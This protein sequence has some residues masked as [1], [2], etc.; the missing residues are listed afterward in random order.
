MPTDPAADCVT[1][2][3]M[4]LLRSTQD[5]KNMIVVAPSEVVCMF[6]P[7][8]VIGTCV[9]FVSHELSNFLL[10]FEFL[11]L[12]QIHLQNQKGM[13]LLSLI[14]PWKPWVHSLL[15]SGSDRGG[16]ECSCKAGGGEKRICQI[17]A[18]VEWLFGAGDSRFL[19]GHWVLLQPLY[20]AVLCARIWREGQKNP[21]E[22]KTFLEGMVLWDDL[23]WKMLLKVFEY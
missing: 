12:P 21:K 17:K 6:L 3:K 19:A 23:R 9:Y 14:K 13:V 5:L 2:R 20:C 7:R 8:G 16:K 11:D 1:G 15:V 18:N 4:P 22:A 10:I